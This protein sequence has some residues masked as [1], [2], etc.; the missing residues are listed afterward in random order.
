[1]D[2]ASKPASSEGSEAKPLRADAAR[3]R[4]RILEVAEEVFTTEG[5][6]VPVDEVAARAGLGVGTLYRHFPT[7]QALFEAIVQ[8]HFEGLL[9]RAAELGE[10]LEPGAAFYAFIAEMVDLALKFKDIADELTR[11]AGGQKPDFSGN[12]KER[13]EAALGRLLEAAQTAG[14]VRA[15]VT[16]LDVSTLMFSTCMAAA[17][18]GCGG[19]SY[20][21]INVLCDG[22]RTGTPAP[23]R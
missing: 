2:V 22:L 7:K 20:R 13:L 21:L 11:A 4:R 15:D 5:L 10:T 19:D 18:A 17:H 12:V 8:S 9:D 16:V 1:M 3:N 23:P 6:A 14:S